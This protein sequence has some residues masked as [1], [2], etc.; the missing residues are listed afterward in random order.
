MQQKFCF[1]HIMNLFS[2]LVNEMYYCI[3]MGILI[4]DPQLA[5][6]LSCDVHCSYMDS[7][8]QKFLMLNYCLCQL[9]FK[10]H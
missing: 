8:T 6:H 4:S 3:Y 5:S 10:L 2:L 1:L 7:Y 9:M